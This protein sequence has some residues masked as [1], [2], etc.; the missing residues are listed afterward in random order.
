MKNLKVTKN[1]IAQKMITLNKGELLSIRGGA[2][3]KARTIIVK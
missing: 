3:G 2:D 1:G